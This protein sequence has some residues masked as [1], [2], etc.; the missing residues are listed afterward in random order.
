MWRKSQLASEWDNFGKNQMSLATSENRNKDREIMK[1]IHVSLN[2]IRTWDASWGG[3][4]LNSF[5]WNA[6]CKM[7]RVAANSPGWHVLSYTITPGHRHGGH[8]CCMWRSRWCYVTGKG[9]PSEI[10]S[11]NGHGK[12][13]AAG[14]TEPLSSYSHSRGEWHLESAQE[15]NPAR[16]RQRLWRRGQEKHMV[17][18]NDLCG[19]PRKPFLPLCMMTIIKWACTEQGNKTAL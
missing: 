16:R 13:R 9:G 12:G 18:K 19:Y 7:A 6:A 11:V 15:T 17:V 5:G 8:R 1:E 10:S 4:S 3:A 2:S 14:S